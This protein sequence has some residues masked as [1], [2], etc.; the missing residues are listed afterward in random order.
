M[1]HTPANGP[2]QRQLRVGE[3]L[4]HALAAILM[5]GELHDPDL[6]GVSITVSEVRP[7]PDMKHATVFV[8]TLTGAGMEKVLP[9][10]RRAAPFLRGQVARAVR[11]RYTPQLSFQADT[12][13]D[14]AQKINTLMHQDVVARDLSDDKDTDDDDGA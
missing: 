4:R 6:A 1:R 10:L 11:L 2:S 12:S 14:Y 8:T 7:S 3:E 9:A 5:R 13:F